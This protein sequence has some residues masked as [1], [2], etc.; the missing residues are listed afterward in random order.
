MRLANFHL[1]LYGRDAGLAILLRFSQ[2][3]SVPEVHR[4]TPVG[5]TRLSWALYRTELWEPEGKVNQC[6]TERQKRDVN[7]PNRSEQSRESSNPK[8]RIE[9]LVSR[10]GDVEPNFERNYNQRGDGLRL[11]GCYYDCGKPSQVIS[12]TFKRSDS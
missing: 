10:S 7:A 8:I 12:S 3:F 5:V 6:R 2:V 9:P 4:E 11:D 1:L